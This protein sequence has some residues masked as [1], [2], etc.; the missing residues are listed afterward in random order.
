MPGPDGLGEA[1]AT[2]DGEGE[3]DSDV[4]VTVV[5]LLDRGVAQALLGQ[6]RLDTFGRGG[7]GAAP[8]EVDLPAGATGVV[9][10]ELQPFGPVGQGRQE[11]EDET[12]NCDEAG[13]EEEP[14]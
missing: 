4:E 6:D 3:G 2:G 13:E 8:R 1:V 12:R 9:D 11:D 14:P 5:D 7:L 10:R